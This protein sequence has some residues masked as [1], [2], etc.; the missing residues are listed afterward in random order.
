[1]SK[2]EGLR[3]IKEWERVSAHSHVQGLGLGKDGKAEEGK[4][5]MIGQLPAREAAGIITKLVSEGKFAGR[6]ALIAGP[7]GT[8][9]TAIALGMAKEL[10]HDVPFVPL[11][12]SEIYSSEMKKTEYLTKIL[13]KAIGV[14]VTEMRKIYEGVVEKVDVEMRSHPLNP[15]QK[16]PAGAKIALKTKDENKSFT[17]DQS[18]AMQFMKQGIEEGDVVQIDIDGGNVAK[19]GKSE[20]FKESADLSSEQRVPVPSG[21]VFK[22]REFVYTLTLDQMDMANSRRGGDILSMMFGSSSSEIDSDLRR[23]IDETVRKWVEI[24]KAEILPGVVFID[25]C[26]MLDIESFAFLNRAMEGDLAPILVFATNRGITEIKGTKIESPHGMPLD[27]LDR[28]LI[29]STQPYEKNEIGKILEIRAK[30]E[31]LKIEKDALKHLTSIGSKTSL[32]YSVQLMA[33]A[34]EL[35]NGKIEEKHVKEANKLFSDIKRSV[36]YLK[37]YEKKMLD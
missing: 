36:K 2:V 17:V 29:I 25:E 30:A 14:R 32:R 35:A 8:G 26:S 15:Y 12:A 23:T 27:L 19:L 37:N 31:K 33:P 34:A 7:P 28:L 16:V 9:K 20:E 11:T 21:E 18:F 5:G 22:E 24:G 3:E 1:M 13:R 10:G 6:A 4:D